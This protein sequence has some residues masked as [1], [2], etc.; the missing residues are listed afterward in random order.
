MPS[1]RN[2]EVRLRG[3]WHP[4]A[5]QILSPGR[6]EALPMRQPSPH[7][8][9]MECACSSDSAQAR[10][11]WWWDAATLTAF[12]RIDDVDVSA[13]AR[14]QFDF[15]RSLQDTLLHS[16]SFVAG[17]PG[18]LSRATTLKAAVD[19]E[20]FRGV[21]PS[22]ALNRLVG[23]ADRMQAN[24]ATTAAEL[25][26]LPAALRKVLSV[27]TGPC[28]TT[29]GPGLPSCATQHIMSAWLDQEWVSE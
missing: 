22:I 28:A 20:A 6:V 15:N 3:V 8:G 1:T 4:D 23:T 24:P 2:Y 7:C 27:H 17:L 11:G 9:K 18:V 26:A 16:P 12:A 14:I 13:G 19:S 25:E 10:G 5:V 29:P 21:M